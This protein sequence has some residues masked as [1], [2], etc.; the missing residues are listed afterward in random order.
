MFLFQVVVRGRDQI[1]GRALMLMGMMIVNQRLVL[2]RILG[3]N[4]RMVCHRH[5]RVLWD[6]QTPRS[7][8]GILQD[9]RRTAKIGL[10]PIH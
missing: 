5:Q 10:I 9:L 1:L 2:Y 8:K 4:T 6:L 3:G 7:V